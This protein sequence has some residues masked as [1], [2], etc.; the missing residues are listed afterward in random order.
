LKQK[1][2][3]DENVPINKFELIC[4]E[5]EMSLTREQQAEK[6]L[7]QQSCQLNDLSQQLKTSLQTTKE[8][9]R[10]KKLEEKIKTLEEV[11]LKYEK[12]NQ[13]CLR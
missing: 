4:K 3:R 1:N 7:S 6:L 9:S 5:L 10:I 12:N 8:T 13:L 11:N 2:I